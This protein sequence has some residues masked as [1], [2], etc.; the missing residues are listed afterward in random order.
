M[1][2]DRFISQLHNTTFRLIYQSTEPTPVII[3]EDLSDLGFS[4]LEKTPKNF[5]LSKM[6][7]IR[8][9][10]F[11]AA[12]FFLHSEQKLD[13]SDF[14]MNIFQNPKMVE[15]MFN[16]TLEGFVAA[17]KNWDGFEGFIPHLETFKTNFLSRCLR[18]YTPNRSDGYN[19]LNHADFHRKNLL[20]QR[21]AYEAIK[22]FLFVRLS[23]QFSGMN[24]L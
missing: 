3:L 11:H 19:V 17:A 24:N 8:L 4:I 16:Q 2:F 12:N 22:D 7:F 23:L 21:N 6:V 9:A 13:Y 10:K 14:T 1:T 20:F 5:A 18:T 15:M